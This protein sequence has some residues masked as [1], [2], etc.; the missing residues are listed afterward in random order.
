MEGDR[1][2]VPIPVTVFAIQAIAVVQERIAASP[3][4]GHWPT[5]MAVFVVIA[6]LGIASIWPR[7]FDTADYVGFGSLLGLT[8]AGFVGYL[9]L[10]SGLPYRDAGTLTER[11]RDFLI[12]TAA[13]AGLSVAILL[14]GTACRRPLRP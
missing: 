4:P 1:S 8:N 3:Q 14:H 5:V 12:I 6:I 11:G 2:L 10:L 9:L 13:L 7:R